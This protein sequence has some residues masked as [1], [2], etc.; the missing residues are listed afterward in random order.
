MIVCGKHVQHCVSQYLPTTSC[1]LSWVASLRSFCAR[2]KH[3]YLP[4]EAQ[5]S[6]FYISTMVVHALKG[7]TYIYTNSSRIASETDGRMAEV[8]GSVQS[9]GRTTLR[10]IG[11]RRA[12]VRF[13]DSPWKRASGLGNLTRRAL[14]LESENDK[15]CL[16]KLTIDPKMMKELC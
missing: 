15:I 10:L 1:L 5:M 7:I 11:G 8:V 14:T 2:R 16:R 3:G 12:L 13:S 4:R 6:A 9:Q